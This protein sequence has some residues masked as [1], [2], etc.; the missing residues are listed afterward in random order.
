[1]TVA[2]ALDGQAPPPPPPD[3]WAS[4]ADADI[5][6][7]TIVMAPG[8]TWTL[9]AA[10]PGVRRTLYFFRGAALGSRARQAAHAG[11]AVRADVPVTLET[12]RTRA[13][14]CSSRVARS[15]SRSP[16]TGPS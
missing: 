12:A 16:S 7:W 11:L 1:M 13:S 9:P 15:A 6:I 5:G 3:S 4:R 10:A 14:C 8:A 2:G